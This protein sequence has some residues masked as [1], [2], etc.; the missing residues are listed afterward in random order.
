MHP[1]GFRLKPVRFHLADVAK[2]S[3][4]AAEAVTD[5]DQASQVIRRMQALLAATKVMDA[6][7]HWSGVFR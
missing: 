4:R 2:K 3:R 6:E 5:L 1:A 7:A